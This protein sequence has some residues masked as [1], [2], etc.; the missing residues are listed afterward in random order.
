[1]NKKLL[2]SSTKI[3]F[4]I[5]LV[6]L[7][8]GLFFKTNIYLPIIKII[9]LFNISFISI[10]IFI[11]LEEITYEK[12]ETLLKIKKELKAKR[13]I[14]Y[15][16]FLLNSL[17]LVGPYLYVN[18]FKEEIN[19]YTN[20]VR[21]FFEILIHM[22]MVSIIIALLIGAY[23][24]SKIF[25][26]FEIIKKEELNFLDKLMISCAN[27]IRILALLMAPMISYMCFY[28]LITLVI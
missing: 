18:K 9:L 3:T 1:M 26:N 14:I 17:A 25:I 12:E 21:S 11:N 23:L 5:C 28:L 16:L 10:K 8:L 22:K 13:K 4:F 7:S 6:I 27:E 20:D 24:I 15:L 2:S 19:I